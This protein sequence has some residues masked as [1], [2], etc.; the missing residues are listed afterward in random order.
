MSKALESAVIDV[1]IQVVV[2]GKSSA[3]IT[4]VASVEAPL[5]LVSWTDLT[6]ILPADDV[7]V[8]ILAPLV[9][10]DLTLFDYNSLK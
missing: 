9:V 8:P 2:E 1:C 3:V 10:E 6:A 4:S 7:V 5:V